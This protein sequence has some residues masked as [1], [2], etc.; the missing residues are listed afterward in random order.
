MNRVAPS[1]G[2]DSI[3]RRARAKIP[4]KLSAKTAAPVSLTP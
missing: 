1:G 2:A 3:A 4:Q